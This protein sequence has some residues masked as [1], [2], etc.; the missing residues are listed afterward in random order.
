MKK[1]LQNLFKL[2]CK[3]SI[4]VPSTKDINKEI[5]NTPYIDKAL[6]LLS[7]M[8]GGATSTAALGAWVTDTG[9]LVKEKT[10][11]VYAYSDSNKLQDNIATVIEFCETLKTELTQ[12]AIALEINGELYFI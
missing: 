8:F 10:T 3:V 12:E 7:Q 6:K 4:Y 9:K 11:L 1:Q 5:N 2:D